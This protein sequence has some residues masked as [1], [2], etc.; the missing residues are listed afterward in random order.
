MTPWRIGHRGACG[1]APEN[2]LLSMRTALALGVDG[3]EFDIQLSRDGEAVVIHDD[4]LERTTSGTGRVCDHTLAEL[5]RMDAGQGRAEGETIPSLRDVMRV[6]DKRCRLL[7]E[8][9]AEHATAPVADIIRQAAAE[10]WEY[11]QLLVCAFDHPQLAQ[12]RALDP[13]IRTCALLAG[14]PVSLARVAEEAGAWA[15]N[16]CIQHISQAL[17]DDAR[18]RG[19]RVIT[20]TANHASHIQRA[21][22]LGVDGIISDFPDRL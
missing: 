20:W 13:N 6:I 5:Q 10:G 21:Q 1:H 18:A 19:L 22:A 16:P 7:I 17:V 3:V 4:T 11:E 2:T 15:I 8:L 12:I 14:I 9:K